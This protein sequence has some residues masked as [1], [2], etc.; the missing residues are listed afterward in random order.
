MDRSWLSGQV[1][2]AQT[3]Q[4]YA[5][6]CKAERAQRFCAT[7]GSLVVLLSM[8]DKYVA[9]DKAGW[10]HRADHAGPGKEEV[11]IL[12]WRLLGNHWCVATRSDCQHRGS[13]RKILIEWRTGW[14]GGWAGLNGGVNSGSLVTHTQ[15][16]Q[17]DIASAS[18]CLPGHTGQMWSTTC[19]KLMSS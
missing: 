18:A 7:T 4:N 13:C 3:R 14:E 6:T 8:N 15:W 2:E 11:W 1:R 5:N 19:R 9:E 16:A 10:E 12:A 17:S